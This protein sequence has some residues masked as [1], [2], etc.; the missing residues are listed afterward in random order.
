MQMNITALLLGYALC[1]V[2]EVYALMCGLKLFSPLPP[3]HPV[4]AILT[5]MSSGILIEGVLDPDWM[6]RIGTES[7]NEFRTPIARALVYPFAAI[8]AVFGRFCI[9]LLVIS[10][11]VFVLLTWRIAQRLMERINADE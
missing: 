10:L 6:T 9:W 4:A 5:S 11:I 7:W 3:V 8:A 2:C 1:L